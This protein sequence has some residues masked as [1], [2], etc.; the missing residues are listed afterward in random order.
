MRRCALGLA[1]ALLLAACKEPTSKVDAQRPPSRTPPIVASTS[2]ASFGAGGKVLGPDEG[3]S[4]GRDDRLFAAALDRDGRLLAVGSSRTGD[5][6][7]RALILRYLPSG[8]LDRS[9]AGDGVVLGP[10]DGGVT[11]FSGE[12]GLDALYAV[13]VDRAGRILVAGRSGYQGVK[14]KALLARYLPDGKLDPSFGDPTARGSER[15]GF[16][17]GMGD[18]YLDDEFSGVPPES[19]F[20]DERFHAIAVD[21]EER[22][23]AAGVTADL[24]AS[25]LARSE[26][27]RS[28]LPRF[29]CKS[30]FYG[31][32]IARWTPQGAL[33]TSF[34]TVGY[35][36]GNGKAGRWSSGAHDQF[37]DLALLDT[38]A[39]S[40]GSADDESRTVRQLLV[41]A[42]DPAG[43]PDRSFNAHGT[44]GFVLGPAKARAGGH[45]ELAQSVAVDD[46]GR[47]LV[48]GVS[49]DERR[50]TRAVLLRLSAGGEPDLTF[51]TQ[52]AVMSEP[53]DALDEAPTVRAQVAADGRI[54]ALLHTQVARYDEQGRPD[55]S[56]PPRW[57]S[58]S[59]R[60]EATLEDLVID[61]AGRAYVVGTLR[62]RTL[63][64]RFTASGELDGR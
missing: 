40:V 7:T 54:Y 64:A 8:D 44:P 49:L 27:C 2:T 3:F 43:G 62:G 13:R 48:A 38:R 16:V 55:P 14:T 15:K 9:F 39:V 22:I 32:L 50:A 17:I 33:D 47:L 58:T 51:G 11:T 28:W 63:A 36:L 10:E 42:Y 35:S 18:E 31:S 61:P 34:H 53:I 26:A 45:R 52:G 30:G 57:V 41:A 21:A 25:W 1:C 6:Q 56:F 20:P 4:G 59:S 19:A 12:Q 5:A 37:L 23:L 29:L 46:K 60:A 24:N